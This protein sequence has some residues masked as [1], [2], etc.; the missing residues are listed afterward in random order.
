[1]FS[2]V[3]PPKYR[4]I[5]DYCHSTN[6]SGEETLKFLITER[7]WIRQHHSFATYKELTL[8]YRILYDRKNKNKIIHDY[9]KY[10]LNKTILHISNLAI[11]H[12]IV[13][14]VGVDEQLEKEI[15]DFM[16]NQIKDQMIDKYRN[17]KQHFLK[18]KIV[19]DYV[20]EHFLTREPK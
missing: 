7:H 17:I 11:S 6:T 8:N 4:I 2:N 14:H 12:N 13:K 16:F 15:I 18:K 1:M 3:I 5:G 9:K 10:I 20:K 19:M